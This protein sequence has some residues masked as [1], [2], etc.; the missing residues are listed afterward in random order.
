MSQGSVPTTLN[1]TDIDYSLFVSEYMNNNR[2]ATQAL[3]KIRPH[4]SY[5]SA[6]AQASKLLTQSNVQALLQ[7]HLDKQVQSISVTKE[8]ITENY[9][10]IR[11]KAMDQDK[12]QVAVNANKEMAHLH[13]LYAQDSDKFTQY[14]QFMTN[15]FIHTK[16]NKDKETE[17][18]AEYE[19]IN[20]DKSKS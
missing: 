20:D 16:D 2:N 17:I 10:E 8:K 1:K 5:E 7:A 6:K 19:D 18:E 3:L 4:L 14:Q 13:N 9:E 11:L 15:I 12:L